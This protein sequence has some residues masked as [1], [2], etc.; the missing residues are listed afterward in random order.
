MIA[1]LQAALAGLLLPDHPWLAWLAGRLVQFFDVSIFDPGGRFYWVTFLAAMAVLAIAYAA[2]P[3]WR[4]SWGTAGFMRFCFP[5]GFFSHPSTRT[6]LQL[7]LANHFVMPFVNVGW[8]FTGAW[9][10]AL[11][12]AGMVW[13]FGPAQPWLEWNAGTVIGFTLL[14]AIAD[15]FGYWVWHYLAHKVPFL[16]A[17]HKVHHSAEVLT[18]LVAGRVHPVENILLPV[19]RAAGTALV[20]APALY[21]LVGDAPVLTLFGMKLVAGLFA[22]A[23]NQLLHAHVPISWGR[24][25]NH[26]FISPATHQIHHSVAPEHWDKNMGAYL[27]V[28]DWM[29]GTLCLPHAGQLLVYG[30]GKEEGQPHPGLLGA[31]VRPFLDA[32]SWLRT[33][34]APS[35]QI[36]PP[37]PTTTG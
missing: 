28:W 20:A 16:W 15:D 29:F 11:L 37:P 8:R 10:A 19:F 22:F 3:D 34:R 23:G 12:L 32:A 31:Y 26:V 35:R 14:F 13:L 4:A 36:A 33:K 1:A 21:V 6:D 24:R 25:L 9:F 2:R 7:I 27:A 30:V 17:F 5:R 18:P